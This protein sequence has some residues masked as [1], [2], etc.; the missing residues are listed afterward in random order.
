MGPK[1]AAA[2]FNS[3][4]ARSFQKYE[5]ATTYRNYAIK[6]R[7]SKYITSALKEARP[8]LEIDQ[9]QLGADEFLLNTSSGTYD[10]R[11]GITDA[12]EHR[13]GDFITKMTSVDPSDTGNDIWDAAL[14]TFFL[15]N[16]ELMTHPTCFSFSSMASLA[17]SS[18][19]TELPP[20]GSS[21]V[22]FRI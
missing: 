2:A 7:D 22:N 15:G 10:L 8:K 17:R 3:Q 14:D 12:H 1:R 6:R 18:G 4:Q 21:I 5:I 9:K 20:F 11:V 19:D 13:A 16:T